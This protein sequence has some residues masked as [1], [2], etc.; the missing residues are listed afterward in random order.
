MYFSKKSEPGLQI[1]KINKMEILFEKEHGLYLEG[2]NYGNILLPNKYVPAGCRIGDMLE[3]FIY[4]DSE[5]RLIATTEKPFAMVGDFAF[6]KVVSSNNYGAFLDWGLPKDLMV[7]FREQKGR[8][9]EEKS[10]VVKLYL[11]DITE[12]IVASS[13]LNKFIEEYSSGLE[14]GQEVDLLI[15]AKASFGYNAI[16]NNKYSGVI[17]KNEI[18]QKLS[19][20]RRITGYIKTIREDDKIDLTLNKTGQDKFDD[21]STHIINYLETHNG[22]MEITGK[23]SPEIIEDTFCTSK[24]N[25][26][27]AIGNLYKKRIIQI[28]D[29]RIILVK[30]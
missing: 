19:I 2:K 20:G 18:F 25:F 17:Y 10:Y 16:I 8:M 21:L 11:D 12:R 14:E 29:D 30:K 27:V 24:R 5:D 7:P 3:V 13:K 6:L 4:K 26:K 28:E 22:V 9:F 23:S 15:Y 1:G